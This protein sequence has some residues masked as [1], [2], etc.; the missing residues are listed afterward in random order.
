MVK[1]LTWDMQG[2]QGE[3]IDLDLTPTTPPYF[4]LGADAVPRLRTINRIIPAEGD[5]I[6]AS[7]AEKY[8]FT[9]KVLGSYEYP[10]PNIWARSD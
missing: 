3:D 8:G 6:F 1:L 2:N 4:W 10:G 5:D 9:S 7:V